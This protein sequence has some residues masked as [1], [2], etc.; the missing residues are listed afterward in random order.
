VKEGVMKRAVLLL[1][2]LALGACS[3]APAGHAKALTVEEVLNWRAEVSDFLGRDPVILRQ[4][5]A[6]VKEEGGML[7]A[8]LRSGR[9]ASFN[10]KD[11]LV[12]D[13]RVYPKP[14]EDLPITAVILRGDVFD[15]EDALYE[16]SSERYF[17][18]VTQ[19]GRQV[20][21]QFKVGRDDVTFQRVVFST[22]AMPKK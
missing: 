6:D 4:R 5:F 16:N 14:G 19:D 21:I 3:S 10:V 2:V 17:A 13:A 8:T 9:D 1:L 7:T 20:G 11:G 15:F 12:A 22:V 18:A